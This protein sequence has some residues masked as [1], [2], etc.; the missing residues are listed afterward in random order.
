MVRNPPSNAWGADLI[1]CQGIINKIPHASQPKKKQKKKQKKHKTEYCN[2]F[3]KDFFK[4]SP[5][6]KLF[7]KKKWIND[8]VLDVGFLWVLG[9]RIPRSYFHSEHHNH[10][11]DPLTVAT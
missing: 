11:P 10:L 1:P 5:H 4:N 8:G 6:Q 7:K 9:N 2:K 3:N